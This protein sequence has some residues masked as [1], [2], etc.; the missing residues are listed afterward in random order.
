MDCELVFFVCLFFPGLNW[1]CTDLR[2]NGR[3]SFRHIHNQNMGYW[4]PFPDRPI[5][6]KLVKYIILHPIPSYSIPIFPS[7]KSCQIP[8]LTVRRSSSV[9]LAPLPETR[10]RYPW[11]RLVTRGLHRRLRPRRC[12]RADCRVPGP[13][14]NSLGKAEKNGPK[15]SKLKLFPQKHLWCLMSAE[16]H[17]STSQES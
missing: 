16:I 9:P 5:H 14:T 2:P 6:L 8:H 11:P 7:Q 10:W 1:N 3:S 4:Y 13:G 12:W 15:M 17:S